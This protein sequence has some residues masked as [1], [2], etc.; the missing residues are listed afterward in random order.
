MHAAE[1][2]E[3]NL[4]EALGISDYSW[5]TEP[6]G[7]NWGYSGLYLTPHDMA[8]IGYLFLNHGMWEGEQ[9]VSEEWV[10]Q[11]TMKHVDANT[12]LPGYGYQWWISPNGYYSAIGYKGQF[13]HIVPEHAL[14][15]V[16]TSSSEEDFGRIQ[17]LLETYVIP[18]VID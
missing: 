17:Q 4:F 1:Y 9:L 2:A 5:N 13:I 16:T 14:V 18:A 11:A 15:M 12:L 6:T 7:V 10:K 3:E 8:K